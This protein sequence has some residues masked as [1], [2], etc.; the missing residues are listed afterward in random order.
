MSED[1]KTK[2]KRVAKNTMYLFVR[3]IFVM[4]ISLFTSRVI[5]QTL[6]VDDYGTYNVVG[7]VVVF[8]S[9]L[10]NAMT[11]A[12]YRYIAFALGE[13][14]EE[15]LT[16]TFSMAINAHLIIAALLL[17]LSETIGLWF[18][19]AKL[20]FP[21]G[22]LL[23]A[24]VAYQFSLLT[25]IISVIQTPYNSCIIAREH[26]SFF[27]VTSVWE[28]VF[29]LLV[30]VALLWLP[31]DNLI[32]YSWL[33]AA[34]ALFLLIWYKIYCVKHFPE[35]RYRRYWDK[36]M[37]GEMLKYSGWSVLVNGADVTVAQSTVFFFNVFFGVAANAVLGVANTVN[38]LIT[39]FLSNFAQAFNPQIIKSY[40]EKDMDYFYKLIYST[41]KISYFLLLFVSFPILANIDFILKLWLGVVPEGTSVFIWVIMLYSLIDAYS[42]PLGTAVHATGKLRTHQIMISSI[43]LLN[44]PLAYLVL[45]LG[46]DAWTA[47]GIKAALNLICSI[48]RPIYM[49]R[50]ILLPLLVYSRKVFVPMVLVSIFS[51]PLPLYLCTLYDE[52][53][54]KL[55]VTSSAFILI[56]GIFTLLLG[57]DKEERNFLRRMIFH[58]H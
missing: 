12:T 26:M 21:E 36:G 35:S 53:W 22:R 52:G 24:N 56:M 31:G 50:L 5:L 47:L 48:V 17:V 44:I 19:N 41:S 23:A 51:L 45:W 3:M 27:A 49:K 6:G 39:Q 46:C 15:K 28:V 57:L 13:G 11:N 18:L 20:V 2:S 54:L 16:R 29:K 10:R 1:N 25:F 38:S 42:T 9:F 37:L 30:V 7:G 8:F 43:K 58:R 32:N 14:N 55:V 34:V 33:L 4:G 40:A